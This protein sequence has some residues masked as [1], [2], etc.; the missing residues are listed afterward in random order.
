MSSRA[1]RRLERQKE[2]LSVT[3]EPASDEESVGTVAKKVNAFSF[4]NDAESDE[5][6]GHESPP[7]AEPIPTPVETNK[8]AKKGRKK[9]SKPKNF[10][11][12][13]EELDKFLEDVRK[14][15][16][17]KDHSSTASNSRLENTVGVDDDAEEEFDQETPPVAVSD[18]N[19]LYFTTS[20]LKQSL[21]VLSI[22]NAKNLD[23]D[24]ELK[25]LFGDLSADI[26]ADANTTT[27]LAITPEVLAQFRKL[28]R[29]TRG[30]G[31]KDHRSVPGT[32]RKLL[33]TRV[34]EDWLPTSHR[35]L[36]VDELEEQDVV[37]ILDY[38]ERNAEYNT[39][40]A[41]VA[42]E[43]RLGVRYFEF[44]PAATSAGIGALEGVANARFYAGVVLRP[45]PD[46]LMLLLQQNP[47]HVPTLLQVAMVMLRQG[48]NRATSLALVDKCLF[49][50]DRC[51]SKRLHEMLARAENAL[52][53]LPYD[54]FLNRQLYLCLFRTINA[55]AER[56]T[57]F[58]ALTYS[59]VLLSFSPLLD[60]MGVRY[61]VDHYAILS[62][63]YKWL[64]EFSASPLVTTYCEW[65]T[66]GIAFSEVL[67]HLHLG[68][69]DS[70][71]QTLARAFK[72]H[73]YCAHQLLELVGLGAV[74]KYADQPDARTALTAET[75]L[76]R[77]PLLWKEQMHRQFLHDELNRLF[78]EA[79]GSESQTS[80]WFSKLF[81]QQTASSAEIPLNVLR[82]AM[83]SGENKLMAKIPEKVFDRDDTFEF[84]LF[85]PKDESVAFDVNIGVQEGGG[86]ATDSL[87]DY[88]NHDVLGQIIQMQSGADL[89]QWNFADHDDRPPE[90]Q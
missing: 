35:P 76:V 68:N 90:E 70:A 84:D 21:H 39:L 54:K 34:K 65:F 31:G 3:P 27:S 12:A 11:I 57:F 88:V 23:P 37:A 81:R 30:W 36:G 49:V 14:R 83:L 8:G 20:R 56:S 32:A 58:T 63:D 47:Y 2:A 55:L 26:I 10:D 45:D 79:K 75:Y 19:Y 77:A 15:D 67:A 64:V 18:S 86:R 7:P 89:D 28:A 74:P 60:P 52:V 24:T 50:F 78:S 69:T 29:L 13:D 40:A 51:L 5:S 17:L 4:L 1:L 46:A 9:K 43:H 71:K 87:L 38:K 6:D 66:P 82:F 73:P 48:S 72:A 61:F 16:K 80:G 53:R 25:T 44:A 41:K 42:A 33:F 59:K 62:G 22:E 85:P